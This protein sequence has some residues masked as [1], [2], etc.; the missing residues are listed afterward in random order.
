M[1]ERSY[2]VNE[3]KTFIFL[4][5]D[6]KETFIVIS[7]MQANL[8]CTGSV[9]VLYIERSDSAGENSYQLSGCAC[10][11]HGSMKGPIISA[12]KKT[13]NPFGKF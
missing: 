11:P 1:Y 9:C 12:M 13:R 5:I 2:N 4:R 6:S 8:M 3:G 7:R 10:K